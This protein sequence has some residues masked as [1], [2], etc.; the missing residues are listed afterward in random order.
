MINT[1]KGVKIDL[2]SIANLVKKFQRKNVIKK[3]F[4]SHEIVKIHLGSNVSNVEGWLCSDIAPGFSGSIYLD[5]SQKFPF[6]DTSVD[7]IYSEHMIEHLMLEQSNTMLSECFRVLK[8]GGKIRLATP[9][10][11]KIIGLY[12]DNCD[13]KSQEYLKWISTNFL[14]NS[15]DFSKVEVINQ[16]FHGWKHQFLFD[17][18]YMRK[19]LVKKGFRNITTCAYGVSTDDHL[20]NLETHHINVGNFDMVK[21]ETLILEAEK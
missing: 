1:L 14:T 7:Y 19:F 10:L 17:E 18:T 11:S 8:N 5:A 6:E 4:S 12:L 16:M 2:K 9:N 15:A 13:D 21:F 20:N 3:Y